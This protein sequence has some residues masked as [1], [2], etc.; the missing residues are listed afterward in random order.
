V[1]NWNEVLEEIKIE[2]ARDPSVNGLDTIRRKY[3]KT[4]S[5]LSGRNTIA[6]YSGW[7]QKP[8]AAGTAVGDMDKSGFMLTINKLVR[9]RGLDLILHTPGGDIA[10]TESLVDY[11][12][13]MYGKDIR[14]IVPQLSMSAGT[15]IAL[16]SKEI[17]MGKH[18]N[19]GPIDPQF[20]GFAC[21]AILNEFEQA[22][23]EVRANPTSAGLWQVIIAKYNPTLLGACKQ[24][25][26][27]SEKMVFE[28]LKDNM[29]DGD[30]AAVKKIVGIFSDHAE[31]KSHGRHIS[32]QQCIDAGLN[33]TSLEADQDFQDAVLTTHHCFLHTLSHTASIKIIENE[34]GVAYIE[35]AVK[36]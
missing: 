9:T 10:A 20:N 1:A 11:L 31:Q 6:Y 30:E 12:Y 16:A 8:G 35:N 19:L 3:L 13:S 18:S 21:Q 36:Q 27:W 23:E 34:D 22:K 33:I 14:V 17:V 5:K 29:C 24:A 7:L 28:W 4:V 15:M 26:E 2:I 32:K 25:I